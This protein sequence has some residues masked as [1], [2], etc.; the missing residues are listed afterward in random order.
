MHVSHAQQADICDTVQAMLQHP[1]GLHSMWS[2]A[3]IHS[4]WTTWKIRE[5]EAP[6]RIIDHCF[7]SRELLPVRRW[8][9]LTEAEVG[10]NAL[11]CEQ[12]PSD[13]VALC[14]E[15]QIKP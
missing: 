2:Q 11:P 1:M 12:Y 5:A 15:L 14:L 13:H 4:G 7:H 10:C 6:K 3:D 8:Q 9:L